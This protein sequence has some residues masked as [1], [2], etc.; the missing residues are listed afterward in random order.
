MRRT[1]SSMNL[2][3]KIPLS[4]AVKNAILIGNHPIADISTLL[5]ETSQT[6]AAIIIGIDIK[7]ANSGLRDVVMVNPLRENPGITARPWANPVKAAVWYPT[8][9]FEVDANINTIAVIIKVIGRTRTVNVSSTKSLKSKTKPT[10]TMVAINNDK[11]IFRFLI[12]CRTS[13]HTRFLKTIKTAS[14][15]AM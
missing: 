4:N 13:C 12:G 1:I 14:K 10:V 7:N 8:G 5:R 2:I 3:A 11:F 15:V 6:R 9:R